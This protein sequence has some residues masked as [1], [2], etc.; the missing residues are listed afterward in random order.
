VLKHLKDIYTC[1]ILPMEFDPDRRCITH[2]GGKTFQD[3]RTKEGELLFPERFPRKE[4]EEDKALMGDYAVAGQYQQRPG[5]REG[6]L[7]KS[8]WMQRRVNFI[9]P[10]CRKVRAWDFAS[11]E[12]K[13]GGNP[14]ATADVLMMETP[15]KEYIIASARQV[16]KEAAAVQEHV[17]ETAKI[18]GRSVII[19]IPQ[20][21]GQAG[22]GQA[23]EYGK[24]LSGY[25]LSVVLPSGEKER[26][27]QPLASQFRLGNVSLLETGD[28]KTDAWIT[29]FIEE[30]TGF[31]G[32]SH[33]DQ[34]DAAAD[35]YLEL[36][37][38]QPGQGFFDFIRQ[39]ALAE[40]AKSEQETATRAERCTM[41]A[42]TPVNAVFVMDGT[43]Y[44]QDARGLFVVAGHHV[45]ELEAQGWKQI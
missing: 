4:L 7:F 22:K 30:L 32:A 16:Y 33:D 39:Q 37:G 18:D 8:A 20:D 45:E 17:I 3:P 24:A 44:S 43:R 13:Q 42:P 28:E 19:R 41:Q 34:V 29:P 25:I 21:P 23:K 10:G 38:E 1:L 2:F 31:P 27:A 5:P 14:D 9:P 35:A 40:A 12:K 26:R 36:A 6:G 15:N 11:T